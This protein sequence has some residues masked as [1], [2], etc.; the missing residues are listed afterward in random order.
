MI[1]AAYIYYKNPYLIVVYD[2][3]SADDM[4]E[5]VN[6]TARQLTELPG[7]RVE[8]SRGHHGPEARPTTIRVSIEARA[9]GRRAVTKLKELTQPKLPYTVSRLTATVLT[10]SCWSVSITKLDLEYL[11]GFTPNSRQGFEQQCYEML[12]L[13]PVAKLVSGEPRSELFGPLAKA[14]RDLLREMGAH[15]L[16]IK[17]IPESNTQPCAHS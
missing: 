2:S 7:V 5:E 10:C 8:V 17:V 11:P 15:A 6:D 3:P 16:E 14:M 9:D 13:L 12:R 1:R 4:M